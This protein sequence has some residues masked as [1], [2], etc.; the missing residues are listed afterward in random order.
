MKMYLK[1]CSLVLLIGV[2]ISNGQSSV[3]TDRLADP[4]VLK[5]V[6]VP[7]MMGNLPESII[8]FMFNAIDGTMYQIPI[9]I[10]EMKIQLWNTIK[11][12][13]CL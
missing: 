9:Q 8:A 11:E 4:V 12:N 1:I 2:A 7:E 10:D 5:G 6:D 3:P 13:D